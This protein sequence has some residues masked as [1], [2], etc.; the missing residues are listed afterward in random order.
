MQGISLT[1]GM[2]SSLYSLQQSSSLL[3]KTQGRL[4]T[5]KKVN[6]ALDDPI[7]FFAAQAHS[8]RATDLS[9][10]KDQMGE[11]IQTIKAADAG[12]E[13]ITDLVASAKSL[14]QSAL[15]SADTAERTSLAGQYD[16]VR[17]QIDQLALDSGYKGTNLLNDDDLTVNFNESASSNITVE[18]FA[19]DSTTLTIS[20]AGT[21][22]SNDAAGN[23]AIIADIAELDVA[24]STLRTNSQTMSNQ[25]STITIRDDYT[26]N[27]VN[28]L[29]DGADKLTLAD[30]NEEAANMLMLQTRQ[31]LALSSLSMA[32]QAAQGVLR[33]F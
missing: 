6:S 26:Q 4:S 15:A 14:A 8:Q 13:A 10:L 27:M 12:I 11:G 5:G 20:A 30:T 9:A 33:L 22:W 32:S 29:N 28:T 24:R 25:L 21:G 19:A 2:R 7:N 18:G 31:Q 3:E 17:T 23:T 1:A 16:A